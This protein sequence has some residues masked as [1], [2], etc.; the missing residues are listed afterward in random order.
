MVK[1]L[2]ED[3]VTGNT[4]VKD[5]SVVIGGKT[6]TN[7]FYSITRC[8]SSDWVIVGAN[9]IVVQ[10]LDN[11][12]TWSQINLANF[13]VGPTLPTMTQFL[14]GTTLK[15]VTSEGCNKFQI[16]GT[17]GTLWDLTATGGGLINGG[18]G[19]ILVDNPNIIISPAVATALNPLANPTQVRFE[20]NFLFGNESWVVGQDNSGLGVILHDP[21]GSGSYQEVP[22]PSVGGGSVP[23]ITSIYEQSSTDILAVGTNANGLDVIL[24]SS[25]DGA[26]WQSFPQLENID[27]GANLL[28]VMVETIP[29]GFM[30]QA[31]AENPSGSGNNIQNTAS[32]IQVFYSDPTNIAGALAT[33]ADYRLVAIQDSNLAFD[34]CDNTVC[35]KNLFRKI[36]PPA[37][38]PTATR[39]PTDTPTITPTFTPSS[40]P[41]FT[42]TDTTTDTTTLTPTDTP[43]FTPTDTPTETSTLTPTLTATYTTTDTPTLT[44]T[45]TPTETTTLTPTLTATYTTTDTPTLTPTLTPTETT[46]LT[47]T[48]TATYTTTNT[49]T[50]TATLTPTL[51]TTETTTLTPTS[52]TTKTTTN[53]PTSTPTETATS[54]CFCVPKIIHFASGDGGDS[55]GLV[56][57]PG[58]ALHSWGP[59]FGSSFWISG[60][61]TG[62]YSGNTTN[63]FTDI[64]TFTIP[65]CY[66]MNLST[67][68]INYQDDD[69]LKIFGNGSFIDSCIW[70]GNSN[71]WYGFH[72]KSG[73]LA[74]VPFVVGLNTMEFDLTDFYSP[75]GLDFDVTITLVCPGGKAPNIV[76]NPAPPA[77]G[78][79]FLGVEASFTQV[80][81]GESDPVTVA[82]FN[83]SGQLNTDFLGTVHFTSTDPNAQLPPNYTFTAADAGVHVFPASLFTSGI[84][85][86]IVKTV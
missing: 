25:D 38:T 59:P 29:G 15:T 61:S 14:N 20:D 4:T 36:I 55:V 26:S 33:P 11:G 57:V 86:I 46:T 48:L 10:T 73:S 39:T 9:G 43:T 1:V 30:M 12:A 68:T 54:T 63:A 78:L 40:T 17:N 50:M 34:I 41:T 5:L 77:K 45:L 74:S 37:F 24:H 66:D 69:G 71:C 51:T 65:P 49:T 70:P 52:T 80:N 75:Y 27:P 83:G 79:G 56:I 44:P 85:E 60:N 47:P 7:N 81:V 35:G 28:S 31:T 72:T 62:T 21:T 53:T 22:L 19:G 32:V 2:T 18:T 76:P 67:Y 3:F 8:S 6:I 64:R 13:T 84:Q 58:F 16:T 82:A 42:T 23:D